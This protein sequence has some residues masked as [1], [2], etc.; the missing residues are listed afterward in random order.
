MG[1]SVSRGHP[2]LQPGVFV[3]GSG[4]SRAATVSDE[5]TRQPPFSGR[6]SDGRAPRSTRRS[7]RTTGLVDVT[8][9][10]TIVSYTIGDRIQCVK[11][12]SLSA[13]FLGSFP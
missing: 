3:F 13:N 1:T 12:Y 10:L 2:W 8:A 6:V 9:N 11:V 7:L 4:F 5:E